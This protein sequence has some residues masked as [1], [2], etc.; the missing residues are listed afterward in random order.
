MTEC[1]VLDIFLRGYHPARKAMLWAK[2]THEFEVQDDLDE[3]T[4]IGQDIVRSHAS[5]V[6][7]A[8]EEATIGKCQNIVVH[9]DSRPVRTSQEGDENGDAE[10][11]LKTLWR[12]ARE[13]HERF[14]TGSGQA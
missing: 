4:L 14:V 5:V 10:D 12:E 3:D 11:K 9:L 7:A 1:T 6:D 8:K 13:S 2:I